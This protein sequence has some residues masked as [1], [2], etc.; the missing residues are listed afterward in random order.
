[1]QLSLTPLA[2]GK[3]YLALSLALIALPALAKLQAQEVLK[4]QNGASVT[5]QNGSDMVEVPWSIMAVSP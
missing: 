4:V 3:K 2:S 5:L 1:M